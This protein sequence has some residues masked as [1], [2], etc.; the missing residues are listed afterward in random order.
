VDDEL[1]RV[2]VVLNEIEADQVQSLL[3]FENIK[4]MQRPTDTGAASIGGSGAMSGSREI[5]VRAEDL[6]NARAIIGEG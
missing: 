5:L 4:S 2:T 1:V 3:E 6:K